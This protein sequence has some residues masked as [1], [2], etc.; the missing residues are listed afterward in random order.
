M[1]DLLFGWAFEV[2][3][4]DGAICGEMPVTVRVGAELPSGLQSAFVSAV[5]DIY[6]P[7]SFESVLAHAKTLLPSQARGGFWILQMGDRGTYVW[8]AFTQPEERKPKPLPVMLASAVVVGR[9][10]W[11]NARWIREDIAEAEPQGGITWP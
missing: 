9:Y 1:L 4:V 5:T 2:A 11:H 3:D 8:L 7:S 10:V 6:N